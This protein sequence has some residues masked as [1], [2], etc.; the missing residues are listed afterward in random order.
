MIEEAS[1]GRTSIDGAEDRFDAD[2]VARKSGNFVEDQARIHVANLQGIESK[3]ILLPPYPI[4]VF[5][6]LDHLEHV[7]PIELDDQLVAALTISEV[8]AHIGEHVSA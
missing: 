2:V 4:M 6:T 1:K 5:L 7:G 3:N 8:P